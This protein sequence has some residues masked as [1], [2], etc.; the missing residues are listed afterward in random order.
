MPPPPPSR[1]LFPFLC[2][3]FSLFL[4]FSLCL[5][6]SP[7]S[8]PSLSLSLSLSLNLPSF[9]TLHLR[10][11]QVTFYLYLS[12]PTGCH[13]STKTCHFTNWGTFTVPSPPTRIPTLPFSNISTTNS[14]P[15]R[16]NKPSPVSPL[17]IAV[18][19]CAIFVGTFLVALVIYRE[20]DKRAQSEFAVFKAY[21][22]PRKAVVLKE[23]IGQGAF[24]RVRRGFVQ[25]GKMQK[26]AAIKESTSK[27]LSRKIKVL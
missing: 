18:F 23:I 27:E 4:S 5:F 1:L 14:K 17:L 15:S 20:K 13:G 11:L 21:S 8:L 6:F 9:Q 10:S 3:P 12:T 7:S 19:S 2:L 25:Q 26:L 24:G 22:V 16:S